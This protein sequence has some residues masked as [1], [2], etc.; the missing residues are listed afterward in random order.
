MKYF[1]PII[2][3]ALL[4]HHCEA[5]SFASK[6]PKDWFNLDLKSDSAFGMSTNKAYSELLKG[7]QSVPVVVAVIDGGT[8]P[9]HPDL[10]E[11]IWTNAKEIPGNNIDDDKN[12]YADDIH[13]WSFIGGRTGDVRQ[14]NLEVTRLYKAYKKKYEGK[15]ATSVSDDQQKDFL[16]YLALKKDYNEKYGEEKEDYD[17]YKTAIDDLE[18]IQK[19]IGKDS[20]TSDDLS[21]Y[22][23]DDT[24]V[25]KLAKRAGNYMENGKSFSDYKKLFTTSFEKLDT[26]IQYHYN[27]DFD[28][29]EIVGDNYADVSE[30]YYGNNSVKGPEARHGTHVA[31]IIG[32][33]RDNDTGM[34]GV[35]TNVKIMIVRVV[36]DGDERDKD[37]ANGIRYAADNGAKVIN[38]SFGKEY[39]PDK[40]A[41][42]EAVR[43][44][45]SKDVLLI[46]AAGN[47][48]KNLDTEPNFPNRYYADGSGDAVSWMEIG[49]SG[50]KG[51]AAAFS[52]YGKKNVDVFAPGVNIYS[53]TPDSTYGNL[54]GTSMAAPSVAGVAALIRSYYPKLTAEEVKTVLCNSVTKVKKKVMVPGEEKK[55]KL[56]KI[57]ITGGIV[58]AY[59]AVK[60]AEKKSEKKK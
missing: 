59:K 44:A 29:R 26:K 41:V 47:E 11:H 51:T 7:K 53:T 35:A 54:N 34:K 28:P 25:Q 33:L 4:I 58:N 9:E 39:S 30:L 14:D 46:H 57:S 18:K 37:V 48:S 36:P 10:K 55:I 52:N 19:E 56:K 42:D 23:S 20:I 31:G 49:A 60:L 2:F 21:K 50:Y 27:L 13:G 5:Q 24:L 40:K 45:V 38:M 22:K 16:F 3:S 43:Y 12:G 1:L 15:T 32:A 6:T 17:L 8:D